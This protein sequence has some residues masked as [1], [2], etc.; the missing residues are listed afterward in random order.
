MVERF[1]VHGFVRLWRLRVK[2]GALAVLFAVLSLAPWLHVMT[3]GGHAGHACCA[4]AETSRPVGQASGFADEEAAPADSCWVC[5]SLGALLQHCEAGQR[6][7]C[8]GAEGATPFFAR[9]PHA[10]A[11]HSIDPATRSQAPPARA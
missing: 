5:Q 1:T 6:L 2:A 3:S 9:A 4:C 8:V 10:P 11:L 7:A